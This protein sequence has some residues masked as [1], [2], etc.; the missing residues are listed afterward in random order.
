MALAV[1]YD[2]KAAKDMLERLP[3]E[4]RDK[5]ARQAANKTADKAKTEMKR[6]IVAVYNL[7]SADVGGALAVRA[8]SAKAGGTMSASLY[9][10]TLSGSRKGRAMNVVRFLEQKTTLG[11]AKKRGKAGTLSDL[12][13]QFKMSG[14]K[15]TIKP[16]GAKS[17]PFLGNKGRTVFRRTGPG[18]LPIEPVQVI[19]LPQMFNTRAL[20]ESVLRKAATDLVVETERAVNLALSKLR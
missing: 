12:F 5:A 19:D 18:R 3:E 4:L 17:A 11:E 1:T 14:G 9:P 10:T 20:N 6:Q 8:A 2:T 16:T 15:K 13:F 7:K